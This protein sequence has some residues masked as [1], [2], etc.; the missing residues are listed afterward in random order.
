MDGSICM[1]GEERNILL[2]AYR[3]GNNARAAR[4]AHIVLL[5]AEGWSYR[6]V[7]GIAFCS[8]DLIVECAHRFRDKG[9]AG[10]LNLRDALQQTIPRW[11]T[12]VAHW[13][14]SR[15][16]QDFGYYRRRWSCEA[17]AEVLAWETGVRLSRETLRRGLRR[18]QYVWRRPR[19]VV[20]PEDPQRAEKLRCIQQL[21]KHMPDDETA[22]FQDEVDVH[23]NPKL[24]NCWMV[25][26]RQTEV[27]TPGNNEKRHVAG[28]LHWRTGT[29]LVSAPAKRRNSELFVAHLN[30]LRRRLRGYRCIHVI[31]DNA[32]FH[33]SRLVRAFLDRWGH[34][35]QLHFLPKYAPETNPIERIW[36]RL[37]EDITRNHRCLSMDALLNEVYD[38]LN[39]HRSFY[40]RTLARYAHAA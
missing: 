27:V 7:R 3:S 2:K 20:G 26:G 12:Q 39:Q 31:C 17:L 32:S 19:P 18:L 14:A 25:R 33:A 34:R 36:W 23:L 40:T 9:S 16:P 4:R 38:W 29:L 22:V 5:L 8:Y 35:I 13:L 24:G 37:H 30:Q 28:S 11:L 6:E 21:L 1:S 15:T 10:V